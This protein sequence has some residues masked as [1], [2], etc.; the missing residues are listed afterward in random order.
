MMH[1]DTFISKLPPL[2]IVLFAHNVCHASVKCQGRLSKIPQF[3]HDRTG[4]SEAGDT[5][6]DEL[7]LGTRDIWLKAGQCQLPD[8]PCWV[9][10]A[11]Q[12]SC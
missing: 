1:V 9:D 4:E 8:K 2:H 6:K 11:S 3:R 5:V 10:Q 7:S 12:M